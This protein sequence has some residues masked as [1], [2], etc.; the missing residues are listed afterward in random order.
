MR[1]NRPGGTRRVRAVRRW[2][3]L[4]SGIL[5]LTFVY[6]TAAAR[7]V[8]SVATEGLQA[9]EVTAFMGTLTRLIANLEAEETPTRES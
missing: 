1:S 4:V 9:D 7:E 2:L 6:L 8:N 5:L 3:H